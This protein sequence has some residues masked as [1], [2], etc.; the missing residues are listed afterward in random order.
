MVESKKMPAAFVVALAKASKMAQRHLRTLGSADREDVIAQATLWCWENRESYDSKIS[1]E[2][3]FAR[4]VEHAKR[5]W[6]KNEEREVVDVVVDIGETDTVSGEV[7]I[8]Q[9][10][11]DL[12][13]RIT[14]MT[15]NEQRVAAMLLRGYSRDDIREQI[16]AVDNN[17][18][19]KIYKRISYI[20]RQLPDTNSARWAVRRAVPLDSDDADDT[21]PAIDRDIARLE[22]PPPAGHDCPPCWRCKWFYGYLPADKI[23]TAMQIVEPEV[24]D[25]IRDT[26]ARKIDIAHRVRGV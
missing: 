5:D 10:I 17:T 3:W 4:A 15:P 16:G 20:Q 2:Q 1:V 21:P 19:A 8:Q 12:E 7:V 13:A 9:V 14:D 22:F 6:L 23:P 25:A 26:E 24:R 18:I 11:E